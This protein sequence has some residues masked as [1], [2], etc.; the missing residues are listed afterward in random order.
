MSKTRKLKLVSFEVPHPNGKDTQTLSTKGLALEILGN[1]PV[2]K[3]FTVKD[4]R[5]SVKLQDKFEAL[6]DEASALELNSEEWLFLK[7]RVEGTSYLKADKKT[8]AVLDSI[9]TAEVMGKAS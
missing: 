6:S 9:L 1:A 4:I 2:D 8:L 5:M 3:G 7:S